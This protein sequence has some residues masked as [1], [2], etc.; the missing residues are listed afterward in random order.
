MSSL[1]E[2]EFRDEVT[3]ALS[4]FSSRRTASGSGWGEGDDRVSVV[5]ERSEGEAE[6]L[7]ELRRYR[8]FLAERGL[9]WVDGPPEHGGRGLPASYVDL[10]RELEA[11][12][13]LPDDAYLR[14]SAS[15]LCPTLLAHGTEA[16]QREL[17]PRLRSAELIACQL[18]SEPGAGSDLAGL[19]TRATR[20]GDGWRITGQKVW[21]SGAHYSDLG[22]CIARTDAD[23]PKHAGL[24]T[25][26]VD[27]GSPGIEVRPIRQLT[28]GASFDEVFLSDVY[29]PDDQRVGE[30]DGG[31]SVV[32]T[33][34]LN[35]RSAIG[36]EV[37]VDAALVD[38]LVDLA[39][40]VRQPLDD[41][42]RD[43]LA[44]VVVRAWATRLTTAR[45][46]EG[47][48]TP[49]PELALTK[50]L[51]TDLLRQMSDVAADVLEAAHVADNGTWGSYAWSELTLGLPG[52]RV[53]GGT[54][55]I[56]KNA[57]GERVLQLPKDAR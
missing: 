39:R 16:Q 57:V 53:G 43:Q 36:R 2:D 38:R 34:L 28:G 30:V 31:W 3:E 15:T 37:G 8:S 17:L 1:S 10:L 20:D 4:A 13:D 25:F 29:V 24:T 35:E 56:L 51:T 26:L 23:K 27:L 48:G 52:L 11:E 45:F 22:L 50:L 33:S 47:G 41:R 18:Y 9:A 21:S 12:F 32:V 5:A 6:E 44:D 7:A 54:D 46:L 19:S 14:F 42:T 40:H 49:G 55:E